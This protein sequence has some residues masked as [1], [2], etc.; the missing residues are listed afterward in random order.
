MPRISFLWLWISPSPK[1]GYKFERSSMDKPLCALTLVRHHHG[2]FCLLLM[3]DPILRCSELRRKFV[4]T[5]I[6]TNPATMDRLPHEVCEISLY[7]EKYTERFIKNKCSTVEEFE[8]L[9][10]TNLLH[11]KCFLEVRSRDALTI[12]TYSLFSSSSHRFCR[13]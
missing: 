9:Q 13:I 3:L 1:R 6:Y 7:Q 2:Y 5:E 4:S 12:I 10:I 8:E 11:V